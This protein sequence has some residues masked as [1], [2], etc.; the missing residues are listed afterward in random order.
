MENIHA[1]LK[2]YGIEIPADNKADFDKDVAANYK[3]QA[4]FE[5][6]IGKIEEERDNFKT[7]LDTA[8]ET[9]KGFEGVDVET[10]KTQL[11]DWKTKAQTAEKDYAEKLAARDFDDALKTELDGY[12]FSSEAAKSAI[13][14]EIREA[15]LKV[16]NGKILGLGDLMES[17]KSRDESAFVTDADDNKA[18]FTKSKS[19]SIDGAMTRE[20]ISKIKDPV[21]RQ[22]AIAAN[23]NLFRKE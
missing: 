16:H 14:A 17:I 21:E 1:I 7:Q 9:L 23:L 20:D 10:M 2:K 12:K 3:T 8:T 6:K 5:K 4:E 19:K 11:E 13:A 15:G 22:N 18:R